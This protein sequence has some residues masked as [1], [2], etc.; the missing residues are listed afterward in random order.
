MFSD[1]YHV[2]Y[3]TDDLDAAKAFYRD[4]LGAT[5]L[6]ESGNAESGSKMAFLQVGGTEVE[7]I[8]PADKARLGGQ[9]GLIYDHIG[10]TVDDLDAAIAQLRARGVGFA[11]DAPRTNPAGARLI[12][13]DAKDTL[14][15]R[16]HLTQPPPR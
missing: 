3:L 12:Y 5:V 7:L 13:L 16:I 11:T 1:V 10:Y 8:E 15:A 2:G 14:G 4:T 6:L 9:T